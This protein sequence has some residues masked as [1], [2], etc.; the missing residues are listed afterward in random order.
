MCACKECTEALMAYRKSSVLSLWLFIR[1]LNHFFWPSNF[2]PMNLS[3]RNICINIQKKVWQRFHGNIFIMA[4]KLEAIY[5][6][7]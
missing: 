5:V 4:K 3:H 7:K 6:Y 1:I 2:F